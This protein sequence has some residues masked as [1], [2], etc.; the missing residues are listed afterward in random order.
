MRTKLGHE[1]WG[2]DVPG[3]VRTPTAMIG[4]MIGQW[5]S[6]RY[7]LGMI[8]VARRLRVGHAM[9]HTFN[10]KSSIMTLTFA[11]GN[12]RYQ[13]LIG[14]LCRHRPCQARMSKSGNFHLTMLSETCDSSL[15][16]VELSTNLVFNP[17]LIHLNEN[18]EGDIR[19]EISQFFLRCFCSVWFVFKMASNAVIDSG[20]DKDQ[21]KDVVAQNVEEQ[22]KPV[23]RFT[24]WYR[25][26]LFNVIIVGLISFTQP[27]IWNALNSM[28]TLWAIVQL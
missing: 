20:S 12:I 27:G 26:P 11:A 24:R 4:N 10:V 15:I 6:F 9:F 25:S 8:Y 7:W 5:L 18:L 3:R 19:E 1:G 13:L 14:P 23:S 17:H 21:P 22:S 16:Q 2:G 28:W